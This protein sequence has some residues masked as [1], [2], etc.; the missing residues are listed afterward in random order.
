MPRRSILTTACAMSAAPAPPSAQWPASTASTP[1]LARSA[2]FSELHLG[3]G[4]GAE[5]VDRDDRRNAELLHVLDVALQIRQAGFERLEIL[6]LEV[7][8][9]STPPCILSARTVATITTH[10]RLQPGF[11]AFDVDEFFRA[12]VGAETGFRHDIVRKLE[13]GRGRDH[14]IAAMRDV[15]ERAAMHEGRRAFQRLHQVGRSASLSSTVIAPCALR[16]PART[17]FWSRV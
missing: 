6:G 1:M 8:P 9:S 5:M 4:V 3:V 15:R 10:V 11:A 7:V 16:S 12:E 17:G 2:F 14:R 13:R